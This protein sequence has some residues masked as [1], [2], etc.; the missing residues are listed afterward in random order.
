MELRS[1]S[2]CLIVLCC[3]IGGLIRTHAQ[4]VLVRSGFLED[5]LDHW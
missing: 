5:S 4:D 1:K 2:I 3:F